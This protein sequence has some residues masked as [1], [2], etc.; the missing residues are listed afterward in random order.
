MPNQGFPQD[1]RI[2]KSKDIQKTVLTGKAL[3]TKDLLSYY[4]INENAAFPR[5]GIIV[6]A[7][8]GKA[9]VRNTLK[10]YIRESFRKN[11]NQLGTNGDFVVR[12]KKTA[13]LKKFALIN[14]Q[15]ISLMKCYGENN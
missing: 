4:L 14:E 8:C 3:A 10:R 5:I 13:S 11:S 12:I 2:S 15:L 7:K 9:C 6:G 1:K